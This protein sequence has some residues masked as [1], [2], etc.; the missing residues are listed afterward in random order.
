LQEG[1]IGLGYHFFNLVDCSL[2]LLCTSCSQKYLAR[3]V[4]C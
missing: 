3:I 2:A 4:L 1:D